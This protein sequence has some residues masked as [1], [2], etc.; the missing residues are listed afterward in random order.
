[1]NNAKVANEKY[2]LYLSGIADK[3]LLI[4]VLALRWSRRCTLIDDTT[5]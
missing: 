1:M 4:S 5:F 2:G 3:Q